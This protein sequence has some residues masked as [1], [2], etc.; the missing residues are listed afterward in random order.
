LGASSRIDYPATDET[1][2]RPK[3]QGVKKMKIE[4][5]K[6]NVAILTTPNNTEYLFSYGTLVVIV[7]KK[8]I[9]INNKGWS[10]TTN[11]HINQFCKASH[12]GN[13]R[14]EKIEPK[15]FEKMAK[16]LLG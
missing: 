8:V 6:K 5:P 1:S 12:H 2:Q 9:V 10:Q 13:C 11:S 14:V 3:K 15:E 7:Y 16:R 4:A